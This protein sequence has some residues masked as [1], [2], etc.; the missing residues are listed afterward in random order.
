MYVHTVCARRARARVRAFEI[1][2]GHRLSVP[3]CALSPPLPPPIFG[4]ATPQLGSWSTWCTRIRYNWTCSVRICIR[5]NGFWIGHWLLSMR[6]TKANLG[7][8]HKNGW[9]FFVSSSATRPALSRDDPAI[10]WPFNWNEPNGSR[11]IIA[12]DCEYG[13]NISACF[14]GGRFYARTQA[15]QTMLLEISFDA[16]RSQS[17]SKYTLYH[18]GSAVRFTYV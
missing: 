16:Y 1:G 4:A 6:A 13:D 3:R 17:S 5:I 2:L 18:V 15:R 8:R 7:P 9:R 14:D 12:N 11:W 10:S